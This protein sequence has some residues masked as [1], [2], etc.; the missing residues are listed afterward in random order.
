MQ[1]ITCNHRTQN[2]LVLKALLLRKIHLARLDAYL[3][4]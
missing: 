3:S 1:T 2:P 4:L